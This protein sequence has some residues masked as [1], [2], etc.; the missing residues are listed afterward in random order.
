MF[1]EVAAASNTE[2]IITGN[3]NHF[4][5]ELCLGIPVFTPAEFIAFYKAE[6]E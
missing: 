4:A 2:C 6:S 3:T 1:V 5:K